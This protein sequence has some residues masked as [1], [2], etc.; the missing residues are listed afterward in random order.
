M[1]IIVL[2]KFC[3]FVLGTTLGIKR[4]MMRIDLWVLDT[5][6]FSLCS[7]PAVLYAPSTCY[8]RRCG[9]G[10]SIRRSGQPIGVLLLLRM[11]KSN[12]LWELRIVESI[13]LSTVL[14]EQTE[15]LAITVSLGI[16]LA[17]RLLNY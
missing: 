6:R 11:S 17:G 1:K 16:T 12:M 10:P 15:Y 8:L 4:E 3:S 7:I 2:H 9:H 5:R 14:S 13:S